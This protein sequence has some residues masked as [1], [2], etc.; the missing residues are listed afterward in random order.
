MRTGD[1][2]VQINGEEVLNFRHED[3]ITRLR[4]ISNTG[5]TLRMVVSREAPHDSSDEED[6]DVSPFDV[7]YGL[8][9]STKCVYAY[10]YRKVCVHVHVQST[11]LSGRPIIFPVLFVM[12]LAAVLVCCGIAH[13]YNRWPC[14]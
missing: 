5:E 10:M 1:Q 14:G 12:L 9:H 7:S 11:W 6:D 3:I 4:A 13:V 2:L 8:V